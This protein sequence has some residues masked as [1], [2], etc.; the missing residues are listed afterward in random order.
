MKT[1]NELTNNEESEKEVVFEEVKE[2][3]FE[4][5]STKENEE[6]KLESVDVKDKYSCPTVEHDNPC[7]CIV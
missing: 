5:S 3:I 1:N 6:S 7:K 2:F 4:E